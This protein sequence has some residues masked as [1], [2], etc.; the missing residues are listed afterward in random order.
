MAL[1]SVSATKECLSLNTKLFLAIQM[2]HNIQGAKGP[3]E[4]PVG[5]RYFF[6]IRLFHM[7]FKSIDPLYSIFGKTGPEVQ[8][9]FA[10]GQ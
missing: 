7:V 5:G 8:I 4:T 6:L 10:N 3:S 1:D 2:C 9:C